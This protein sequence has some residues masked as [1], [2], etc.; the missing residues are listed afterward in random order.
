MTP[1]PALKRVG[2]RF[3]HAFPLSGANSAAFQRIGTM[4]RLTPSLGYPVTAEVEG[5]SPFSVARF[6]KAAVQC[7]GLFCGV[8]PV[9]PDSPRRRCDAADRAEA[10]SYI[11]EIARGQK[12]PVPTVSGRAASV[13]LPRLPQQST[14]RHS[15][16]YKTTSYEIRGCAYWNLIARVF[17]LAVRDG[18]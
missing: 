1:A 4:R 16:H 14:P 11:L 6:E 2:R 15:L 10:S 12:V 3:F 5:S 7:A 8:N 9:L 18:Q 13:C 17:Q